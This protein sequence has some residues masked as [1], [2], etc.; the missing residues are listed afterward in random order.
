LAGLEPPPHIWI[1]P[2]TTT[3]ADT[4]P[5]VDAIRFERYALMSPAEKVSRVVALTRTACTL[6]L[7][8]LRARHPAADE[9][10]LL[11]RLAVLRLGAD[12]VSR[13]YGW[14]APDGA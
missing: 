2:R 8:G 3:S 6:A 11:L 9:A 12:A 14:R 4:S 13:A 10:E 7:A 5:A 1:V